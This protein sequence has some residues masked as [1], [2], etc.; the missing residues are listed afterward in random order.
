MDT[1]TSGIEGYGSEGSYHLDPSSN[2]LSKDHL[3]DSLE[4][5]IRHAE[6]HLKEAQKSCERLHKIG[7]EAHIPKS[8]LDNMRYFE[9][10]RENAATMDM[11]KLREKIKK[12]D[13]NG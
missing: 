3:Q 8:L 5:N 6:D 2:E 10:K 9:G 12:D 4:Y 1:K 13:N 11:P 7:A